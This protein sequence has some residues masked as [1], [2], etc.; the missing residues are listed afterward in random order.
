MDD[1][2]H[3]NDSLYPRSIYRCTAC[4]TLH[5]TRSVGGAVNWQCPNELLGGPDYHKP[6]KQEYIGYKCLCGEIIDM[7]QAANHSGVGFVLPALERE[8]VR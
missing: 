7:R 8:A 4:G 6:A 5:G 3:S 1:H 2:I